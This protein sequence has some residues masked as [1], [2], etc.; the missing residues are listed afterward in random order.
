MTPLQHK[1]TPMSRITTLDFLR[2]GE[3]VGGKRYRGQTDD[4]LSDKG[5]AQM[6]A[7]TEG[8]RPWQAIV[9]SP[10][11]RCRAFADWLAGETS[12]PVKLEPGFAEV[13]FGVWEGHTA[14]ELN[15][16]DPDAVFDFK[17]DPAGRRPEGAEALDAFMARVAAAF[18]ATLAEHSG[19]Q[20]LVVAHAGVMR[21]VACHVLGLDPARAYRVNVGSAAVMRIKVEQRGAKRLDTLMWLGQGEG[22]E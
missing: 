2:H 17:R 10:L 7:A 8:A 6:Q 3:P 9:S 14:Q 4:P 16:A 5:W 15:Q 21:M 1:V 18:E 19:R 22:G 20:V 12:L 13:G 11:S